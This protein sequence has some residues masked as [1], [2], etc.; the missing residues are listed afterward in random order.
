M[1]ESTQD[2]HSFSALKVSDKTYPKVK[3]L[4]G[5]RNEVSGQ[6]SADAETLWDCVDASS[7]SAAMSTYF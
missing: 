2:I 4:I 1:I 6:I 3:V 5:R 7:T